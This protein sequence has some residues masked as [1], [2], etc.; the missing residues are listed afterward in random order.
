VQKV[1][2]R[3]ALRATPQVIAVSGDVEAMVGFPPERLLAPGFEILDQL[4]PSDTSCALKLISGRGSASAMLRIR[5]DDGRIRCVRASVRSAGRRGAEPQAVLT[6]R[7]AGSHR[8]G[9]HSL[10]E[11]IQFED[12]IECVDECI[13]LKDLDHMVLMA[14]RNYHRLLVG[15]DGDPNNPEGCTDYDR[16]PESEADRM[17]ALEQQVIAGAPIARTVQESIDVAGRALWQD[18]RKFP[19]P[20]PDGRL[21]GIIT[22][23]TNITERV[24]SERALRAGAEMLELF[25]V[26]APAALAMFDRQMRYLS[27]SR[28]WVQDYGLEG[29]QLI[30]RSHYDVFPEIP[31]RWKQAYNRALAGEGERVEEDRFE[32]ADGSVTWL[33]WEALP[34]T[35]QDGSIGGVVLFTE[36]ITRLKEHEDRLRQAASVFTHASEGIMIADPKGN[37]L[38]VNDAFTR[39][40]GYA[41]DEVLGRNPRMLNSGRQSPEFYESMW[42]Q[43]RETGHWAGELWNRAKNGDAFAEMLTISAVPSADGTPQQY[44]ALFSDITYQKEEEQRIERLAHY[45]TL[46][47]LPNRVLLAERL[48]RAM[49]QADLSGCQIA[50]ACMDLDNFRA[51]N[52]RHGHGV[53][54]ELLSVITRRMSLA[55]RE[56]DTLARLGGDEFAAVLPDLENTDDCRF[57]IDAM[58]RAASEPIFIGDLSLQISV[59]IGVTYYPQTED[60]DGDQLLRQADQAMYVAKLEGKGRVHIFDPSRDRSQ[61]GRHEKLQRIAHGLCQGEMVLYYQPKVNMSTGALLGAEALIRWQHPERGLLPPAEFLPV[62]EGHPLILELGD[63]VLRTALR[64]N[65]LWRAQGLDTPVSVNVDAMQLQQPDFADH[66]R[67]IL[68][69]FPDVPPERLELEV[70]E[71]S[72]IDDAARVSLV[73]RACSRLGVQFALDD[74]GTGYSTLAYLKR[75]PVHTL[76]IDQTFVRGMLDDPEDLSI[77]EGVLGLATAFRRQPIAEGVESVEHGMLLLRLG[78]PMAQGFGIA[79]PM[80]GDQLPDWARNWRPDPRW[81][82]ITLVDPLHWPALYARAEH[83]AWV[84]AV[85][86]YLDG[87]RG[88]PPVIDHHLC[89][90][91]AWLDAESIA[92]RDSGETFQQADALHR[93]LHAFANELMSI[94]PADRTAVVEAALPELHARLDELLEK[95]TVLV[96]TL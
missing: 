82:A 41:R 24:E 21:A 15:P 7:A 91:G 48:H 77:L 14:N 96:E 65:Q 95:L 64:Q 62:L 87:F 30:G 68:A 58:L 71:S 37:L 94:K 2:L 32:R 19:V 90:F 20:D 36:N 59:S 10:R 50:I 80:P 46:T 42:N 35:A 29:R 49:A 75:L 12:V 6:L 86:E 74:F 1:E 55:L 22:I 8:R 44:V 51:V 53:G 93:R 66:L 70:L 34:W 69:E 26:H 17:Y 43:L 11:T 81:A 61:R 78:C 25:I 45:D 88:A 47:G 67:Q 33:R 9:V 60:V 92:G 52:D 39:I 57:I 79:R 83:C 84:A 27:V 4:H 16:L 76:K 23:I 13:H 63:W 56:S 73:M 85:E 72:A 89:R 38:D 5:G 31:E 54:D 18:V 40:T 3:L 28:R